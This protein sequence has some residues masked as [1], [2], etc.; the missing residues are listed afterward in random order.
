MYAVRE[1][2][3][4][5]PDNV[6]HFAVKVQAASGQELRGTELIDAPIDGEEKVIHREALALYLLRHIEGVIDVH[7]A[8]QH[9]PFTYIVQE[10]F[11]VDTKECDNWPEA[12]DPGVQWIPSIR[13]TPGERVV[14]SVPKR[15]ALN[16]LQANKVTS[17]LIEAL[18]S[19][20]E[21]WMTHL[22]V[23][24]RNY[25]VDQHLNVS[26]A[27]PQKL[28]HMAVVLPLG[29]SHANPYSVTA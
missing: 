14:T 11:G 26:S 21:N 27:H 19:V 12:T 17:G 15:T 16:A 9:G 2:K 6:Q 22:D 1:R 8:Y 28:C 7:E 5:D 23:S 25:L 24:H 13:G 4:V 20:E 18:R 3:P 10:F 29:Q